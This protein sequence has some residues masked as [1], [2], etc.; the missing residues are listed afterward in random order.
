MDRCDGGE[1]FKKGSG[2][3]EEQQRMVYL[4][5]SYPR[6]MPPPKEASLTQSVG[7]G[8]DPGDVLVSE[9]PSQLL[10][11]CLGCPVTLTVWSLSP[12][13]KTNSQCGC[14]VWDS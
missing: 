10:M 12:L 9:G 3:A 1:R 6:R 2:G 7:K 4:M 13:L 11:T 8:Q 14:W 5:K